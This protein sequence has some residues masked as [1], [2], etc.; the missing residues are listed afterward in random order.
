V[1]RK[2]FVVRFALIATFVA[3][4]LAVVPG[5]MAKGKPG[6]TPTATLFASCNPCAVGSTAHFWGSGYDPG[7]G[8]QLWI[9]Y[10]FGSAVPVAP[11]GSVSFDWYMNGPGMYDVRLYQVGNGNK[12]VL[13]GEVITYAQ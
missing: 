12:L 7:Q 10:G 13:K 1:A 6:A 9:T 4:V 11:D 8:A 3:L 5:A 2:S